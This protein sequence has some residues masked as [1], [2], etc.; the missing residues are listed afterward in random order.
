MSKA[1]LHEVLAV[2][3]TLNKAANKLVEESER[4]F[5]KTNLFSGQLRA[6]TMFDEEKKHLNTSEQTELVT[7]VDEN[8]SYITDPIAQYW[9]AVLQKD[10]T[11]QQATADIVVDGTTIAR[12]VPATFLLGLETK[13]G[14]IR[15]LYDSIGTLAPGYK[16][17]EDAQERPGIF[18]A[19]DKAMFKTE[20]DVEFKVVVEPTQYHPAQIVE[21]AKTNNVG[22]YDT[23]MWSGLLTPLEKAMRIKR[24]DTLLLAVKK[25]RQRANNTELVTAKVGKDLLMF[26]NHGHIVTDTESAS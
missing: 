8:L 14:E 9:D 4:T 23:T 1:K 7:T 6:L 17:E 13:L 16:W 10:L 15:K 19:T 5:K 3:S 11:N 12:D 20:K 2:E 25:A 26:I 21:L 24:I 22:K 18:K